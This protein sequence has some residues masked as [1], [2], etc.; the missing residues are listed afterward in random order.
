MKRR[1]NHHH[2]A[3]PAATLRAIRG[4]RRL[5]AEDRERQKEL[6]R[7]A[8]ERLLRAGPDAAACWRDMA[9]VA[10]LAEQL[11]LLRIGGGPEALAAIDEAQHALGYMHQEHQARGTWALRAAEREVIVPQLELLVRLH[12]LQLDVCSYGEFERAYQAAVRKLTQARAGNAPPG[13]IVLEGQVGTAEQPGGQPHQP[14][15]L[16]QAAHP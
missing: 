14:Q 12:E 2:Q 15:P 9:D 5:S 1:S 7:E 8:L 11:A 3:D 4:A 13:A 16:P 10:N 6:T